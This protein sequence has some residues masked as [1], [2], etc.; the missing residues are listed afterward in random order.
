MKKM[1]M[2][3]ILVVA[4]KT[5]ENGNLAYTRKR[6]LMWEASKIGTSN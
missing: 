4:K 3:W 2:R 5:F 1:T 6:K